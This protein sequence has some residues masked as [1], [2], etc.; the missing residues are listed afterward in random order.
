M[1]TANII[2]IICAIING[3]LLALIALGLRRMAK[4]GKRVKQD[5]DNATDSY[6]KAHL[7]M[8]FIKAFKACRTDDQMADCLIVWVPLLKAHGIQVESGTDEDDEED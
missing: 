1:T 4:M 3:A 6:E 7:L 5:L 8:Q 2:S